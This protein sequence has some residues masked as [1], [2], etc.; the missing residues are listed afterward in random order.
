MS[1]KQKDFLFLHYAAS[2]AEPYGSLRL[3]YPGCILH[4]P[5]LLDSE[6]GLF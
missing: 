5:Q 4:P 2:F 3:S 1:V 6:V